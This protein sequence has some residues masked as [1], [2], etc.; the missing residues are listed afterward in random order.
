MRH[1]SGVWDGHSSS[2]FPVLFLSPHLP[3]QPTVHLRYSHHH[4]E[5]WIWLHWFWN[6]PKL[7]M[8]SF[9]FF[10]NNM[11]SF[12]F[13]LFSLLH[14][15]ICQQQNIVPVESHAREPE[16]KCTYRMSWITQN[17]STCP[18]SSKGRK[19]KTISFLL[20]VPPPQTTKVNRLE[21]I[22]RD[23]N[24]HNSDGN[25]LGSPPGVCEAWG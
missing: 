24:N 5:T 3:I 1:E 12:F 8:K 18:F 4:A 6:A 14:L 19:V 10:S 15:E 22:C 23:K 2:S 7:S 21:K 16:K 17:F 11:Y 20:G 25:R 13:F 9:I